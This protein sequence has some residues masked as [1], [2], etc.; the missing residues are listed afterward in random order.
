VGPGGGPHTIKVFVSIL[1]AFGIPDN[2]FGDG[3]ATGPLTDI[4]V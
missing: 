3:T 2:T 4:M 1:N